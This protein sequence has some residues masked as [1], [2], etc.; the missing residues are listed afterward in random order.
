[1]SLTFTAGLVAICG[2]FPAYLVFL[3]R[4]GTSQPVLRV[5]DL[6]SR[7]EI[8]DLLAFRN[9]VDPD[10]NKMLR[11][12]LSPAVYRRVQRLR[13]RAAIAYVEVVYRNA[14]LTIRLAEHLS[15]SPQH[16][17]REQATR[18]Q[19]LSIHSRFLALR[20]LIK[21][22]AS[23]IFPTFDAPVREV[24]DGYAGIA[25]R[26]EALCAMTAPLYTSRIAASFR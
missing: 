4:R 10:E 20:S 11:K 2:V 7:L 18:I 19:E 15:K 9:L 5:E 14:G 8:V 17:I 3:V 22:R 1:M 23:L 16:E 21:L 26:I 12:R 13:I 24:T 6:E 25:D